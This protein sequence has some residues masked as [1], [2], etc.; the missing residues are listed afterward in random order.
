M[1]LDMDLLTRRQFLGGAAAIALGSV[2]SAALLP[3]PLKA[4]EAPS[5]ALLNE[6]FLFDGV[7]YSTQRRDCAC[8]P[9]G[10]GE[11]KRQTGINAAAWSV[12]A[13]RLSELNQ[14]MAGRTDLQLMTS[15]ADVDTVVT[16]GRF[17]VIY[18]DQNGRGANLGSSVAP[19]AERKAR[20]L[21]IFQIA[22]SDS[23]ELGGGDDPRNAEL[24]LTPFGR[25]VVRE[26]NRLRMVVDVSHCGRRT[27]LDVAAASTS[28]ILAT[29]C[30]ARR[31]TNH[32]RAKPDEALKAIA[33][34]GGV[35]GV[36]S[37]GR[38]IRRST[39]QGTIDDYV[40]HIDY[41][42][43]L[44][45]VDHVGLASDSWLDGAPVFPDLDSTD[46]FLMSPD[47]WRHVVRRLQAK[48]YTA[49]ALKKVM[50]LNFK[51]VFQSVLDP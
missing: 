43:Q 5:D 7:L 38:M 20:G 44:V 2:I 50:G 34:T 35:I 31:L 32:Y 10:V 37:V 28:P 45:G 39:G 27:T 47:R 46:G 42:V 49:D 48:G 17:G 8:T 9:A 23:S 26:L 11:I 4:A 1:P 22:Y 12:A 36:M 16:I 14:W 18:Y 33:Q 15:A 29:H 3:T 13:S 21:R 25:E 51:R 24:P 30:T 19:L 40:A 6:S 41:M